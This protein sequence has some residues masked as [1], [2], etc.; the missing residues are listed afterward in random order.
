MTKKGKKILYHGSEFIINPPIFGKGETA[1]DYG[2]GFYMTEF[3]ELAAEWACHGKNKIG[4]VNKYELNLK[5]LHLLDMD[6]E[7][8]ENWIS[9]LVQNR[10]NEISSGAREFMD[11]FIKKY[12]F[13]VADYDVVKGWRADDSYYAFVLVSEPR[14]GQQISERYIGIRAARAS[15]DGVDISIVLL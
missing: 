14:N 9:I 6:K 15:L 10:D 1:N 3:P 2:Q 7:P 4:I 5:E 13:S 8:I 11:Q 12:P